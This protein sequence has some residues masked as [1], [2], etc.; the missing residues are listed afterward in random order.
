M[1]FANAEQI[2]QNGK[3]D[4]IRKARKDVLS[5]LDAALRA[6]DPYETVKKHI[7]KHLYFERSKYENT[8]LLAFGKASIPMANAVCDTLKIK[9]GVVIT[10]DANNKTAHKNVK[11]F[12]ADHPIPTERNIEATNH[13][14]SMIKKLRK[15]DLLIVLI[16]GGGSALFCKPKVPLKDIQKVTN[17]LLRSGANITEI[18][19][20]RKHLSHVK[21]GQLAQLANCNII[22]YI[23]SD[24]VGDP[25]EFIASGPTAPDSTTYYDAKKILK[26]YNLWNTIPDSIQETITKGIKGEIPETP[27]PDDE[28]FHNVKNIIV[29]SNKHACKAA[30]KKAE[31][32]GYKPNIYSTSLTGEARETGK[33]LAAYA[34]NTLKPN[35]IL[36]AGG[37]TTVTILGNGKGGRNQEM[38]LSA[39]DILADNPLVFSSFATDGIDGISDAAGAVSDGYTRERARTKNMNPQDYLSNNDSYHFFK[40]LND[41][42]FTGPTGTNVMDIQILIHL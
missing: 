39:V 12:E 7:E 27:K 34:K 11:T 37:E 13:A 19:T 35:S 16:S 18:N 28:V 4:E 30:Y 8:Y 26:R 9:Q 32:L 40:T 17:L 6:V 15:K 2:I 3:T 21:G 10:N 33:Q 38:V 1:V 23:I 14:L 29:A 31:K 22:S 24:V 20:I 41:L 42:L 25:I 5:I 36:I